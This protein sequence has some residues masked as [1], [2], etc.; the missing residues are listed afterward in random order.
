[1]ETLNVTPGQNIKENLYLRSKAILSGLN[2]TDKIELEKIAIK[3][4]FELKQL[5]NKEKIEL[6]KLANNKIKSIKLDLSIKNKVQKNETRKAK[7]EKKIFVDTVASETR[8]LSSIINA[9]KKANKGLNRYSFLYKKHFSL[10]M[11][12]SFLSLNQFESLLINGDFYTESSIITILDKIE[13]IDDSLIFEFY[14]KQG[15]GIKQIYKD[16]IEGLITFN[17]AL[18]L[19]IEAKK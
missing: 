18:N 2:E 4:Q 8:S 16:F 1:M 19:F 17:D 6:L 10:S 3:A 15:T 14:T 5:T 11:I 9:T 7:S 12:N 13:K